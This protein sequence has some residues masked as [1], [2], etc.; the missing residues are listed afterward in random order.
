MFFFNNTATTATYTTSTTT[1]TLA[2]GDTAAPTTEAAGPAVDPS[3]FP[4]EVPPGGIS[5]ALFTLLTGQGVAGNVAHC[6]I[7]TAY[8]AAGGEQPLVDLGLLA[9]SD[10]ALAIVRQAAADCGIP[11][12]T[13]EAAI[14]VQF[15][16]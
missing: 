2:P 10:E 6:A 15:G 5:P 3:Q 12:E 9:G 4:D 13:I 8:D 14:A 7:V 1:T 16:G 11:T